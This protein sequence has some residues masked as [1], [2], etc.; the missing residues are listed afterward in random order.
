MVNGATEP[1]T[2]RTPRP[3]AGGLVYTRWGKTV[4]PNGCT[5]VY[6][7]RAAGTKYNVKGGTSDTL[8]MPEAPQY[9][10][11]DTTATHVALLRG[12]EFQ[13]HGTSSTPLNHVLHAN[14]PC[15][16]CHTPSAWTRTLKQS[17]DVCGVW[18]IWHVNNTAKWSSTGQPPLCSL[19]HWHQ[20]AGSRCPCSVH[21]S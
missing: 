13:T 14:I 3:Q 10:S 12:V 11:T 17:L 2:K 6:A 1:G 19:P 21:L 8:C 15:A 5:L 18:N 7:G 20:T 16:V 9:L 4:C